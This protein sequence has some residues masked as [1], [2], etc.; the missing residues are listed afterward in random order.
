MTRLIPRA[1]GLL[2]SLVLIITACTRSGGAYAGIDGT[3][4]PGVAVALP[5]I[6]TISPT[7]AIAGSDDFAL[8]VNGNNFVAG[9]TVQFGGRKVTSAFVSST[10]L[11]GT[12]PA[13]AIATAGSAEVSVANPGGAASSPVKFTINE[14]FTPGSFNA[15]GNM[16]TAR[17]GHAAVLLPNGK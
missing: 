7:S 15:I 8:T 10:Q 16:I 17:E 1:L 2:A 14:P 6:V 4:T 13:A 9:S 5:S 12:V 3:G 11:I